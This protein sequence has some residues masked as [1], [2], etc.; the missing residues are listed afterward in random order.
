M[1]AI[2][3]F[4]I[5]RYFLNATPRTPLQGFV[6][7]CVHR[8][9]VGGCGGAPVFVSY[10][11]KRLCGKHYKNQCFSSFFQNPRYGWYDL[12]NGSYRSSLSLPCH[13]PCRCAPRT[14]KS[15][16]LKNACL[17]EKYEGFENAL[18][19]KK[20]LVGGGRGGE[21]LP[22]QKRGMLNFVKTD[23]SK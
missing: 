17:I 2:S 9:L 12:C 13:H 3:I 23:I 6:F 5:S 20:I 7:V 14:L 16:M 11:G 10:V 18:F 19:L 15:K 8:I 4:C 1:Y 22:T 21:Q